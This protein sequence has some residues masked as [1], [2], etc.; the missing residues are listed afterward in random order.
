MQV[1]FC[2]FSGPCTWNFGSFPISR[3]LKPQIRGTK[4]RSQ[5]CLLLHTIVHCPKWLIVRLHVNIIT[6][7]TYNDIQRNVAVLWFCQLVLVTT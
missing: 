2:S 4:K 3:D 6:M 5:S 1:K 7:Y